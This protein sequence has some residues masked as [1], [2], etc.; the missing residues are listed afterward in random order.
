MKTTE[1]PAA[2]GTGGGGGRAVDRTLAFLSYL[3]ERAELAKRAGNQFEGERS[4][5]KVLGYKTRLEF[6]DYLA[7]YERQDVAGRI[8]DMPAKETWKGQIWVTDAKDDA[9]TT[10]VKEWV[11][12]TKRIRLWHHFGRVDRLAGIGQYAVLLIGFKD[13]KE[14]E[15]PVDRVTGGTKSVLYVMPYREDHA[16]IVEWDTDTQSERFGRPKMYEITIA[17]SHGDFR[18]EGRT[19]DKV[20]VHHSRL[21]HVADGLLE[22]EVYGRPRLQRVH[23]RLDDLAKLAGGSPEIFWQIAAAIHHIDID[24]DAEVSDEDLEDLDEQIQEMMHNLRRVLQ[25]QGATVTTLGGDGSKVAPKE[26]Y[27]MLSE[28]IAAAAE[29]PKRILFGSER[30]ELASSQDQEEWHNRIQGR[31]EEYAE[32]TLIRPFIERLVSVGAMKPP[33]EETFKIEWPALGEPSALELAETGKAAAEAAAAL[34]PNDP[35]YVLPVHEFREQFLKLSPVPPEAPKG[36][37]ERPAPPPAPA[38]P[39]IPADNRAGRRS[40]GKVG[41]ASDPAQVIRRIARRLEPS[42]RAAFLEAV[43]EIRGRLDLGVLEAALASRDVAAAE[44][45]LLLGEVDAQF[46]EAAKA[47]IRQALREGGDA[48]A[49]AIATQLGITLRFNLTNSQA[50]AWIEAHTAELVV[51]VGQETRDAIRRFIRESFTQGI[52]PRETAQRVYGAIGLT[53]SQQAQ[54]QRF[55]ARLEE[56]GVAAAKVDRRVARYV[57]AQLRRRSRVIARHEAFTAASEGQRALWLQ[58][59]QSGLLR[60]RDPNQLFVTGDG[61]RVKGPPAHVQCRCGQALMFLEDGTA[62]I[63]WITTPDERLCPICEPIPHL[64]ANQPPEV[65]A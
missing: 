11:E 10:F 48:A 6:K 24:K 8:V 56:E 40:R 55:R 26:T 61:S 65:S 32:P 7:K 22:D 31:R 4:L 18:V 46:G 2:A 17:G 34:S 14:L 50:I 52:T 33:K 62:W 57:E 19:T 15:E 51:Q 43:D 1:K 64:E 45:A 12:L 28:L 20:R 30:G 58:A 23:D 29:I 44:V 49:A 27:E 63:V 25:T 47:V 13:G 60:L 21:L 37:P 9:E 38:I 42:L 16:K 3:T 35:S 41:N 59:H 53:E 39:P 36:M 5:T 54:V